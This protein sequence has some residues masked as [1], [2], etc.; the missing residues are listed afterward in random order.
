VLTTG[1]PGDQDR[2]GIPDSS[3]ARAPTITSGGP[4]PD[5]HFRA[6][7]HF[8]ISLVFPSGRGDK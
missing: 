6:L 4:N 3:V 2:P 8:V 1:P 7:A 5:R